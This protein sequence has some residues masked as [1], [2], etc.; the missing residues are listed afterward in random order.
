VATSFDTLLE[1]GIRAIANADG[2]QATPG[3]LRYLCGRDT[4]IIVP[5]KTAADAAQPGIA[6]TIVSNV[7]TGGTGDRRRV[8]LQFSAFAQG[9]GARARVQAMTQRLREILKPP[10][11]LAQGIDGEVLEFT[12]RD[13]TDGEVDDASPKA[14]ARW[15]LDAV[16]RGTAPR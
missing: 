6:M 9:S 7:P 8:Q 13:G 16:L 10:A 15:D 14:K 3:T 4:R 5:W 11:L 2:P 12:T 1:T